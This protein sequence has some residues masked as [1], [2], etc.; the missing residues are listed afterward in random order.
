MGTCPVFA[1]DIYEGGR[2]DFFPRL[3]TRVDTMAT[4]RWEVGPIVAL[5]E[6]SGFSEFQ[7]EYLVPIADLPTYTLRY[8]DK[9]V[10]WNAGAPEQLLALM[11]F[12]DELAGREGWLHL[13][14]HPED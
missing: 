3:Y 14:M 8:H 12:L 5:F 9:V 11:V 10:K 13:D 4:A 2:V 1:L 6:N 7:D